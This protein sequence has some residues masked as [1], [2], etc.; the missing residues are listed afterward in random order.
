MRLNSNISSHLM[1]RFPSLAAFA[2]LLDTFYKDVL[3]GKKWIFH[4]TVKHF[5]F[6]L[7]CVANEY[8]F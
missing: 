8:F 3:S 4:N 7:C 5:K 6:I 2:K 1:V